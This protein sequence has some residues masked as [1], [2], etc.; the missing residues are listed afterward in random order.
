MPL[1]PAVALREQWRA[2]TVEHV[3][4]RPGDWYHPAVD[5]LTEALTTGF[6][7]AP[8][9][10]RLGEMRGST[11]VGIAEALDDLA[12]VYELSGVEP[13]LEVVRALCEGWAAAIESVPVSAGCIDPE[14]GL[15]TVDYLSVRLM[16]TYGTA[17]RHAHHAFTTHCLVLVDVAVGDIHPWRRAA[18]SAAMGR[19][20]TAALP[21]GHPMASLGGGAFAVLMARDWDLGE[22]V[23]VLRDEVD[24]QAAELQIGELLRQPPRIWI[25]PLPETHDRAVE[26]LEQLRR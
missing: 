16:E 13:P 1:T 24:L 6:A 8:A 21:T 19:A 7:A 26:L 5:A 9:A 20:L 4:L 2:R 23:R 10:F 11:G 17:R 3:W 15:P 12:I 14:S 25:E 22:T 18:R